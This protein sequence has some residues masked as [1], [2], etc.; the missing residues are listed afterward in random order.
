MTPPLQITRHPPDPDM[1]SLGAT[2][3]RHD[4]WQRVFNRILEQEHALTGG[5]I[6]DI[7]AGT[8][9][10][11]MDLI[12]EPLTRAAR[13][14]GVEPDPAVS[15]HPLLNDRWVGTLEERIADIPDAAYDAAV[16]CFVAEHVADPPAH[17]AAV[18]RVL[19]P[20]AALFGYTPNGL[21]PFAMLSRTI[22]VVGF[23]RWFVHHGPAQVNDYPAYYRLNTAARIARA[24]RGL[25]FDRLDVWHVPCAHWRFQF[26]SALRFG[27]LAFEAALGT[28]IAALNQMLVFRLRK[29]L[30]AHPAQGSTP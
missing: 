24:A 30:S 27:P 11:K 17:L 22:E 5:R 29:A 18:A 12:R 26:P 10:P 14:D 19:K 6:L 28:K 13:W 4:E 23:K 8:H 25:P 21:H 15:A 9:P 7:G 3:R 16:E 1:R 2:L 20:G